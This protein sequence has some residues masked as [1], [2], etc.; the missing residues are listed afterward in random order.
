VKVVGHHDERIQAHAGEMDRKVHP[1]I[2][3]QRA[4]CAEP[5]DAVAYFPEK[6]LA[7]RSSNRHKV[8]ALSV[9]V[10]FS[11]YGAAM[12]AFGIESHGSALLNDVIRGRVPDSYGMTCR[13]SNR[14]A[15][16]ALGFQGAGDGGIRARG[17]R[18]YGG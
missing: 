9:V 13:V 1:D 5:H 12:M 3:N 7:P 11:P 10:S 18:P 15:G 8:D 6:R 16:I 17:P 14:S 4:C 2:G